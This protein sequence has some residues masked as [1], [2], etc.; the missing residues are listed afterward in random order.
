MFGSIPGPGHHVLGPS[1]RAD[2]WARRRSNVSGEQHYRSPIAQATGT[3]MALKHWLVGE[4]C[5]VVVPSGSN[6]AYVG[7]GVGAGPHSLD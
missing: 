5:G 6:V 1:L 4:R 2:W 7:G 3:T